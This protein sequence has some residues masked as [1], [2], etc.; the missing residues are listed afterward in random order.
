MKI[1]ILLAAV[2]VSVTLLSLAVDGRRRRRCKV[3]APW[4]IGGGN[5][6]MGN[7]GFTTVMYILSK[8]E[9]SNMY[10]LRALNE[11]GRHFR[12][13]T[14]QRVRFIALN[15]IGNKISPD[16]K[17]MFT[18]VRIFQEPDDGQKIF[19]RLGGYER[20]ILIYD[21]CSRMQF[22]YGFPYSFMGFPWVSKAIDRV[23]YHHDQI[24]GACVGK[25]GILSR[26]TARWVKKR[27]VAQVV[28]K[29][30]RRHATH[31]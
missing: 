1:N 25:A 20:D 19:K 28:N 2:L 22:Q 31:T 24:C 15:P 6:I 4:R 29:K 9:Y 11:Y 16:F 12:D 17:K 23:M 18:Y 7:E 10:Q 5:P 3:V 13:V 14:K 8:S 30:K 21:E 26:Q 27:Q